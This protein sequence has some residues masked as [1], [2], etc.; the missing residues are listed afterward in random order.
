[1][2]G[3]AALYRTATTLNAGGGFQLTFRGTGFLLEAET[4]QSGTVDGTVDGRTVATGAPVSAS[5]T[6]NVGYALTGLPHGTHTVRVTSSTGGLR[7]DSVGVYGA[8]ARG[9]GTAPLRKM[10]PTPLWRR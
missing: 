4:G 5:R 9:G 2:V 10:P 3:S 8:I 1:M 6:R 7:L